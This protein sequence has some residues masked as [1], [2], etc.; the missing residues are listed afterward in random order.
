MGNG[1]INRYPAVSRV[2]TLKWERQVLRLIDQRSLP[3]K[4]MY[5]SCRSVENVAEAIKDMVVRG[6]PAIGVA[7]GYGIAL[8]ALQ[9]KGKNKEK[10]IIHIDESIKLLSGAR[11]TA[12]NLF[13]A[14]DRMRDVLDEN[15]N[16]EIEKIR[17]KLI[18]KAIEIEKQDLEINRKIGHHGKKLFKEV[19]GNIRILT[20]CNAGALATSGY[21]TALAVIRSLSAESKVANV[22]VDETRPFLQGARL[23]A[24]ELYQEKIPFFIISD[25]MA[26]Y[27]MSKGDVDAVLV[28]ADRIASNGDTANKIGTLSLSIL[29]EYYRIPFYVAAPISTIDMKIK[30]GDNIPIEYRDKREV[31]EILGKV[32]IPDFMAVENP[33]FDV[34]PADKIT[35]IITENG[36]VYPPYKKTLA[37]FLKMD[38]QGN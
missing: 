17:E 3:F 35:A 9:F 32:I 27:F 11:P 22:I 19:K 18:E 14:L 26:G 8:A 13:W 2:C 33:A 25:N 28:G 5:V 10:F 34:T 38:K 21:G 24:W 16:L 29:A 20:H 4:E 30:S 36:V 7:A 12:I 23:T 15:K 31:R 37:K 6:A 1:D